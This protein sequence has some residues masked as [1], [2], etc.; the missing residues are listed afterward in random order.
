MNDPFTL[1]VTLGKAATA[2]G[3]LYVDD[4]KTYDFQKELYVWRRFR[5]AEKQLINEIHPHASKG[6]KFDT[7]ATV[8]RIIVLGLAAHPGVVRAQ[9]TGK[10]AVTLESMFNA[11]TKELVIR[12]PELLINS[13]WKIT[14]A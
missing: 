1:V 12:K 11:A 2:T 10:P 4:G 8:E 3:D 6:A 5:F 7:A 9:V 14:L 13:D